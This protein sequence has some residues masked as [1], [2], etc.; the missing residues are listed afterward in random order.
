MGW[1]GKRVLAAKDDYDTVD[2][3][4]ASHVIPKVNDM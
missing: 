1:I 3:P 4:I 2:Q